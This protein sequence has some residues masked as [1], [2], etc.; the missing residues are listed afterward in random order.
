MDIVSHV[1]EEGTNKFWPHGSHPL[2]VSYMEIPYMVDS[3]K[4]LWRVP[5]H[6]IL[7]TKNPMHLCF[8]NMWYYYFKITCEVIS[9]CGLL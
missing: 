4:Q 2:I 8:K 9:K 1:R 6:K 5:K 7:K 3:Y